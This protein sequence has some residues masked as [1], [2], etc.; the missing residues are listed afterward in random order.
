MICTCKAVILPSARRADGTWNVK[1]RLTYDRRSRW[2]PTPVYVTQDQLT[3]SYKIKDPTA[4]L[5]AER[6]AAAVRGAL[7]QM[8]PFWLDGRTVDDAVAWVRS[9]LGAR[10][11]RLDFLQFGREVA[12]GKGEATRKSYLVALNALAR[13]AGREELDVAEVT[14]PLLRSF[15]DSLTPASASAY[16]GK[17]RYV[18][19]QARR[20]YDDE[21]GGVV[22]IGRNPFAGLEL[23]RPVRRGQRSLGVEAMQRVILA[24]TDDPKLRRAL[25]WFVL[26][27]ALM[28]MNYIDLYGARPPKGGVLE[29]ERRKTSGRRADA[30]LMRVRV[31]GCLEPFVARQRA[32][33]GR[34]WLKAAR[35]RGEQTLAGDINDR[36]REWARAEGLPEFTFYAAR[37]TW[38]TVARSSDAGVP[39]P[40]VE[41]C[42]NHKAAGLLDIYAE[43]DWRTLDDANA[44]VLALF[45][46]PSSDE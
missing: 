45:R 8:P 28:G 22:R 40:V 34:Y 12:Q 35:D 44:R 38:A 1:I 2:L 20:R 16:L 14:A 42:L 19:A 15:A 33:N 5:H 41:D 29:Y 24:E 4:K 13:Y 46:W 17:L 6:H 31:P 10:S 43:R 11:F 3:R 36:L 7:A 37:H 39:Y 32:K 18:W 9:R 26:S 21:D 23:E 27:F 30:A 25:D